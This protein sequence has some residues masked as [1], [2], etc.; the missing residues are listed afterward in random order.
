MPRR[1]T[2]PPPAENLSDI[3]AHLAV[4][5]KPVAPPR[6]F[7][8]RLRERVRIPEPRLIAERIASWRFFFVAV[9]GVMSAMVLVITVARA[10]FHL[11][12]RR[13]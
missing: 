5:L 11:V 12:G 1:K 6:G 3:E 8:Q 7:S 9:G 4:T 10:L 2:I 13:S